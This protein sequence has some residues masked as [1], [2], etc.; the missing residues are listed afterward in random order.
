MVKKFKISH[1]VPTV[2]CLG[3]ILLAGCGRNSSQPTQT[4]LNEALKDASGGRWEKAL[5]KLEIVSGREPNNAA[6]LIFKAL[7]YEG[8][9]KD[10]LAVN[11]AR[12]AVRVAPKNFQTQYTLGR[13]Y[14]KDQGKMQDAIPPLLRA[15]ELKPDNNDTLVLLAR[16]SSIL[17]L[18][19]AIR[20]YNKLAVAKNFRKRAELWN[21][22]GI[23]YAE[24]QQIR[25]AAECFVKAYSLGASKPLIV[26]N[27]ATFADQYAGDP[28]RALKY[29]RSYL[30]ITTP[31][32][33]FEAQRKRV[34]ARIKKIEANG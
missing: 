6:A 2:C 5:D 11:T 31:S 21:E 28:A 15:L 3:V 14:S 16:C 19:S 29:Y 8:C 25:K 10:D 24:R 20:Y 18:D 27:F 32:P 23:Y 9:G 34:E 13:L 17:K 26:L 12:L 33:S 30:K 7:A 22:M 1:I 4:L